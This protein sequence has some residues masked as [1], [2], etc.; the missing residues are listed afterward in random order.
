MRDQN[1][2]DPGFNAQAMDLTSWNNGIS[3]WIRAFEFEMKFDGLTDR[4]YRIW[5]SNAQIIA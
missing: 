3:D 1:G 4:S 2:A 5:S